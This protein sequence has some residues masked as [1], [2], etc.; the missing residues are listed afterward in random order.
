[1]FDH[2]IYEV[3]SIVQKDQMLISISI[4]NCILFYVNWVL[5]SVEVLMFVPKEVPNDAVMPQSSISLIILVVDQRN[6]CY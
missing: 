4:E 2:Q 3:M 1:M 6:E 5:V